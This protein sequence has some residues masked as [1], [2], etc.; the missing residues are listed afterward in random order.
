MRSCVRKRKSARLSV[1]AVD[2]V[3]QRI[4]MQRDKNGYLWAQHYV[5]GKKIPIF[6]HTSPALALFLFLVL[7]CFRFLRIGR[8][9]LLSSLERFTMDTATASEQSFM[10]SS[11]FSASEYP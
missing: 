1:A 7:V 6:G 4:F 5:Y 10:Y 11:A 8:P 9:V 2:I 3:E